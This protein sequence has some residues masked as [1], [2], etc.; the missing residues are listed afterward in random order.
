MELN[1]IGGA[2]EEVEGFTRV[3][4]DVAWE[5]VKRTVPEEEY[6]AAWDSLALQWVGILRDELGGKYRVS[7]SDDY[8]LLSEYGD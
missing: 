6:R 4:W 5:T 2:L 3:N 7:E 1:S 8:I